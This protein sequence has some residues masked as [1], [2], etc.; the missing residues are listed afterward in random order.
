MVVLLGQNSVALHDLGTGER[1]WRQRLSDHYDE[2]AAWPLFRAPDLF[3]AGPFRAGA[4]VFRFGDGPAAKTAW[5]GRQMSQD[6]CSGVLVDGHV[7]GFDI[8][9]A[10]ASTHRPARG[11]FKCLEL[12]TGTV[13]W[14]TDAVGGASAVAADGK[15]I[16]LTEA[17]ELVLARATPAGYA[18]LGR[19]QVLSSLRCAGRRRCCSA[20]GCTSGTTTGPS[21]STSGRGNRVPCRRRLAYRAGGSTGAGWCRGSRTFRTTPR[22][23]AN[24]SGGSAGAGRCS[25]RPG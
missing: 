19:A 24:S 8:H 4:T 21:A 12:A 1:V 18:E 3:V 17:G 25:R 5:A 2:H 10:Q 6:V 15:L 13:A 16:L 9:Q 14:E 23:P 22:R 7:Y 11:R 20:G